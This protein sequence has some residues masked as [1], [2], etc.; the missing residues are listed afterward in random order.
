MGGGGQSDSSS[1][2]D[3]K[4]A[5][6]RKWL[7][8]ALSMYGQQLGVND[9]VWQGQRVA[10]LT[11]LQQSAITGAGNF[12]DYF[13]TP[14]SAGTPLFKTTGDAAKGLLTGQTG[15]QKM[16][17]PEI[18]QYFTETLYNPAMRSLKE[19]ILPG[20]DEDYAGP[21]FF[22]S[23]RSHGRQEARENTSD[24]LAQ[25]WAGLNWDVTQRNQDIDE[26]KAGRT[27]ATLGPAMQY[28]QVPAQEIQNNLQ[29]AAQQI[30]GLNDIFGIGSAQQTQ[31]QK[32]LTAEITKFAEDNAITDPENLSILL[33]LLGM[34][35]SRSSSSASSWNVDTGIRF[36]VGG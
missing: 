21:G 28:G 34:D 18:E 26:A 22:G 35:F 14:Q 1:Q 31:Q 29:I 30:G 25:Q 24:M 20:I 3:A 33:T 6:Q 2:S 16:G 11:D 10:P 19:D 13:S 4:T 17:Q 12:A 7:T 27:L 32:E 8:Q 23:A 36:P 15:A 9:N 5:E